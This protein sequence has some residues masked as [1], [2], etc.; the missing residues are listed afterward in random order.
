MRFLLFSAESRR[1]VLHNLT[2]MAAGSPIA[3]TEG[4]DTPME[5]TGG[6]LDVLLGTTIG[7]EAPR[8]ISLQAGTRQPLSAPSLW[9][10]LLVNPCSSPT[11]C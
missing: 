11:K 9:L 5:Y 3:G 6:S 7:D 1:C 8:F 4:S 10:L 2:W